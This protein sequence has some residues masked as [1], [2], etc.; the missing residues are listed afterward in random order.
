MS[1]PDRGA[2][3]PPT[4]EPL[5]FDARRP[6]RGR[7]PMPMMLIVSAGIL[8]VLLVGVV[9]I[10]RSGLGRD[11][12]PPPMVGKPVETMKAP[13]PAEAQ[14][15]DPARGL[16]IYQQAEGQAQPAKPNFTPPPEQAEART[17]IVPAPA[18]AQPKA[19]VAA[20]PATEAPPA[21]KPAVVATAPVVKP[22]APKPA[23]VVVLPQAKPAAT[24]VHAQAAKPVAATAKAASPAVKPAPIAAKPVA[25]KPVAAKPA[26]A[27][28]VAAKV[29]AP[30]VVPAKPVAAPAA[31]AATAPVA[32]PAA[33]KPE[34]VKPVATPAATGAASVQIGAFSS[35]ALADKGWNDAVKV[36][37][38]PAAGKG[39]KVEAV[40]KNGSTLYRT[41]VTGFASRDAASAFC[42]QLKS[43]GKSCFVK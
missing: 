8:F 2:Y 19:P 15:E 4:E 13:P 3:S 35:Q 10:L 12:G 22:V 20:L 37:P 38:G 16:Q 40:D 14:P 36:A 41:T 9:V 25:A 24:E 11:S 21:F 43:A 34:K 7:A 17:A 39:K 5:T 32:K 6:V 23:P 42:N 18:P 29:V 27:P 1:N 33:E 30:K 28:P 31:K 26:V